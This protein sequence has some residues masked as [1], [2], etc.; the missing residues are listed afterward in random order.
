MQVIS[1]LE[2]TSPSSTS[3]TITPKSSKDLK[4]SI[5]KLLVNGKE[6][7][8]QL[9]NLFDQRLGF[10]AEDD[11]HQHVFDHHSWVILNSIESCISMV[12]SYDFDQQEI[13]NKKRKV[14][15]ISDDQCSDHH[16]PKSEETVDGKMS[17]ERRG[18]YKRRRN[19]QSWS[20]EATSLIDDGYAWR[21]YGQKE[22]LNTEYPRNY[23]RCTHKTD[24]NCQATKQVQQISSNPTKYNIIYNGQHTCKNLH[25]NPSI[26]IDDSSLD[27][28]PSFI[29]L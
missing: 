7:A 12:K 4:Q 17:K 28:N 5:I 16:S 23:Y 27:E 22:I 21:K 6:S 26:I 20:I 9:R 25:K 8:N 3:S 29:E 19:C 15:Q 1:K 14:D 10:K 2:P 24:Q 18:C 11:D 13:S